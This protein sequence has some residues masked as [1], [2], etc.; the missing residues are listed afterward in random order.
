MTYYIYKGQA[1][2]PYLARA[3]SISEATS[4]AKRVSKQLGLI[5]VRDCL[6]GLRVEIKP[7]APITH[8]IVTTK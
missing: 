4:I 6:G 1:D 7:S 2:E 3:E 5:T 8:R